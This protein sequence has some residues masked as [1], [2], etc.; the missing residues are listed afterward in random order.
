MIVERCV[1]MTKELMRWYAGKSLVSFVRQADYAHPGEEEAIEIT[2]SEYKKDYTRQ[3]LDAGCGLGQTAKYIQEAGW[4]AATGIDIENKAIEYARDKYKGIDFLQADISELDKV[5]G[6]PVFDLV[7]MYTV[8][9]ALRDQEKTLRSIYN[10]TKDDAEIMIFDYAD[11]SGDKSIYNYQ[12]EDPF[13]PVNLKKIS[14]MAKN[15]GWGI[16][17]IKELNQEYK[18]WYKDLLMKIKQVEPE[19]KEVY[20]NLIYSTAIDTYGNI[21]RNIELKKMGGIAIYLSKTI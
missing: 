15:T 11:I 16:R 17:K 2:L 13:I 5:I 7:C 8:F 19:L 18:R 21:L 6:K 14:I 10:I 9:Y 12:Q 20:G 3:V 4:G 1:E